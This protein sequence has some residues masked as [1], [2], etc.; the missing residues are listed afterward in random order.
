M[1]AQAFNRCL[2]FFYGVIYSIV[3]M[4]QPTKESICYQTHIHSA[5]EMAGHGPSMEATAFPGERSPGER[6]SPG[7]KIHDHHV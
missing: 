1:Q 5:R 2:R 7:V 4:K 3:Y 6:S